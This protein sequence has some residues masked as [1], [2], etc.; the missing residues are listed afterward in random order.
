[1]ALRKK[2]ILERLREER[3][4]PVKVKPRDDNSWV[5]SQFLVTYNTNRAPT[6]EA[7]TQ[8]RMLHN[9]LGIGDNI[10]K[11]FMKIAPVG[12]KY[13]AT[14]KSPHET[15]ERTADVPEG[16][17]VQSEIRKGFE[18]TL[19]AVETEVGPERTRL[20][21]HCLVKIKHRSRLHIDP[22]KFK[23]VANAT[24]YDIGKRRGKEAIKIEYVN[25]KWIPH[26]SAAVRNYVYKGRLEPVFEAMRI[27]EIA[28]Q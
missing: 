7:V 20:H 9:E 21:G 26:H 18:V 19:K 5:V 14:D 8:M 22:K 16:A 12:R 2:E 6:P 27:E 3:G 23:E 17:N 4:A 11:S 24:L 15:L 13:K 25:I 1:M 28:A 10:W